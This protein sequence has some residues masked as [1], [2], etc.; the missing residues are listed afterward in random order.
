MAVV[1]RQ[2]ALLLTDGWSLQEALSSSSGLGGGK[3]QG[4][5]EPGEAN[6][7]DGDSASSWAGEDHPPLD[8]SHLDRSPLDRFDSAIGRQAAVPDSLAASSSD[9]SVSS[10]TAVVAAHGEEA[11]TKD[12]GISSLNQVGRKST[13]LRLNWVLQEG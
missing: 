6:G 7:G 11:V 1:E 2:P 3:P 5:D 8:S 12:E 13:S 10:A 4:G 9:A